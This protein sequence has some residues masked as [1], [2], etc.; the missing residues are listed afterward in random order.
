MKSLMTILLSFIFSSYTFAQ[1]FEIIGIYES[2]GRIYDMQI[3]GDYAYL[4]SLSAGLEILDLSDSEYPVRIGHYGF[5]E[6]VFNVSV[7]G[8]IA[9][10][11]S[12]NIEFIDITD[13]Y[14]PTWITSFSPDHAALRDISYN[15]S[16]L[17]IAHC[18]EG[19]SIYDI[20]NLYYPILLS[21][22]ENC[23]YCGRTNK[24]LLKSP[25]CYLGCN[26]LD[27]GADA[28]QI[29]NLTNPSEPIIEYEWT[30]GVYGDFEIID[31]IGYYG[32]SSGP[33][34]SYRT[35]NLS[36]PVLPVQIGEFYQYVGFDTWMSDLSVKGSYSFMLETGYGR[37]SIFTFDLSDLS[38]PQFLGYYSLDFRASCLDISIDGNYIFATGD[39]IFMILSPIPTSIDE[40][41]T[42]PEEV[43]LS[44]C[45]PNPFNASTTI[46]FTIDKPSQ[47]K[48][49]IY[50]MA[51]RLVETLA[52]EIYQAGNHSIEWQAE[53]LASGIYFARLETTGMTHGRKL[54]LLK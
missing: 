2:E 44:F 26:W 21:S 32:M 33:T 6:G 27:M 17:V 51:G 47:V 9:C 14:D 46:S 4:A 37:S 8:N 16:L 48:I 42:N 53:G 23:G 13:P 36:N 20:S 12:S 22:I 49:S 52:D 39:S 43:K 45:Y 15:D 24:I 11:S 25:Y 41:T 10:L 54:V 31:T 1:N 5:G 34:W 50:D 3:V 7:Q 28:T 19:A 30:H 18:E 29:I 40:Y 38:A 35:Y